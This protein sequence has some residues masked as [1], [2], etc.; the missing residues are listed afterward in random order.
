MKNS[1]R[2]VVAIVATGLLLLSLVG[3][4]G[5]HPA[6]MRPQSVDRS[7]VLHTGTMVYHCDACELVRHCGVACVSVDIAEARRRGALPCSTCGGECL[8]RR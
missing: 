5:L 7:V 3:A 2:K 8:A 6:L 4:L 1:R